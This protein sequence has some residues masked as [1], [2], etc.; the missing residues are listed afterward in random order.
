MKCFSWTLNSQFKFSFLSWSKKPGFVSMPIYLINFIVNFIKQ[1]WDFNGYL[2][3]SRAFLQWL[4]LTVNEAQNYGSS[5][6]IFR[7]IFLR[8]KHLMIQFLNTLIIQKIIL[9]ENDVWR[10]VFVRNVRFNVL[11][12]LL[13]QIKNFQVSGLSN[14]IV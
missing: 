11:L 12:L 3:Q 14:L 1:Y 8:Q 2:S 13:E 9:H 4:P 7:K 6:H 5:Q 10:Y